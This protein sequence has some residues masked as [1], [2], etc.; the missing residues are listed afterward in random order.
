MGAL[1]DTRSAVVTAAL[2]VA[3]ADRVQV[4]AFAE[5]TVDALDRALEQ[6]YRARCM[7]AL[8]QL[9]DLNT[10]PALDPLRDVAATPR[11]NPNPTPVTTEQALAAV[12][13]ESCRPLPIGNPD[14]Y[15]PQE[16]A[17]R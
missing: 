4:P 16:E 3:F 11:V 12:R 9:A 8:D 7:V 2:R 14:N 5:V 17:F 6:W 1:E 10:D 13:C 15:P